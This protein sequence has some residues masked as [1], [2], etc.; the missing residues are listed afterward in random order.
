MKSKSII[1]SFLLLIGISCKTYEKKAN[2][3]NRIKIEWV[4][5]LNGDFSFREKWN[6]NEG[7]YR[8]KNGE[9]RLDT[10]LFPP[11]FQKVINRMKDETGEIFKDSLSKYYKIIDTT[12]IF[13][14]IKSE[15]NVYEGTIYDH[16]EFKKMKNSG[17]KG[18][19]INNIS[20]YSHLHIKLENEH[21]YAWNQYNSTRNL[22]NHIFNL[23][24]GKI[25]IDKSLFLK[26]II[27]A[28]FDFNFKNTLALKEKLFWKGKIYSTIKR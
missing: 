1:V 25:L 24:N 23:K 28:E 26:G 2:S 19:T 22:G 27:K 6:Y 11:E 18:E 12:H 5:N 10:G 15:T 14:S 4:E 20:G 13:H 21:C 3:E 7:I 17:I 16:M 9:L 8:N